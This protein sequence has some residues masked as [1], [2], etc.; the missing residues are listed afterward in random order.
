VAGA[1]LAGV[2]DL[3]AWW[4]GAA[5]D[6]E[7]LAALR[8]HVLVAAAGIARPERFFSLLR[9]AGLDVQTL[10]LDD[11]HDY[12][13]LPWPAGTPDVV[14]TE[15]DAVK[16]DPARMGPTRVWVAA[17]DFAPDPAFETGLLHLLGPRIVPPPAPRHGNPPA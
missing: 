16:L 3:A 10:G 12:A 14:V 2:V 5:P 1:R 6:P 15:K 9:A 7:A 8:G 13:R 4:R 17:L 11:H